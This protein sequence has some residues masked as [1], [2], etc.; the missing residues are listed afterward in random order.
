MASDTQLEGKRV[1]VT[2]A[3]AG[4]GRATALYFAEEGASVAIA[5]RRE[6]RLEELV[7]E[8]ES[9]HRTHAVALPTDVSDSDQ[10]ATMVESAVDAFGELDVV[11]SNA[12]T[13]VP[14]QVT[15]VTDEEYRTMMGVNVDGMFFTARESLLEMRE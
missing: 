1:L 4:V 6:E 13:L 2:G 14:S 15:E 11:V 3:S 10:V 7:D 9:E 8:I 5:A 12:G